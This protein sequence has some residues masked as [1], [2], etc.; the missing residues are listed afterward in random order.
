MNGVC[1]GADGTC[2]ARDDAA[3]D[4]PA[5]T[6]CIAQVALGYHHVCVL[7]AGGT[8]WCAGENNFGQLGNM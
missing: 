3:S 6:S 7:K 4:A 1:V 5:A 2:G 8:I